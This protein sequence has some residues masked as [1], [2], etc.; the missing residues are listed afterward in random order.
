MRYIFLGRAEHWHPPL[1]K[2]ARDRIRWE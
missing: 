2:A 1:H